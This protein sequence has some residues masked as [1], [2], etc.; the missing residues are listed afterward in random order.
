MSLFDRLMA[1]ETYEEMLEIL[2]A[3]TDEEWDALSEDEIAEIDVKLEAL[4]PEPYPAVVIDETIEDT[5]QS[6]IVVLSVNVTNVAPFLTSVEGR[7]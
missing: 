2:D 4:E 1:C 3:T 7:R 5:V 6:E